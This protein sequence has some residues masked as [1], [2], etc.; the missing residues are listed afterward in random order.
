MSKNLEIAGQFARLCEI[1][2]KNGDNIRSRVYS[3][4]EEIILGFPRPI[5]D[6]NDVKG[7]PGIGSQIREKIKEYLETGKLQIIE[8][9]ENKPIMVLTNVYGIGAKKANDLIEKGIT[10]I[11]LLRERQHEV[12]NKVQKVG[13]QYYDDILKRIPRD[14]IDEYKRIF[15]KNFQ[16]TLTDNDAKFEI[17][18]SYRRG[19]ENSGDIDVIITSKN[20]D[21]FSSFID[22]LVSQNII[23]EVLSR[24]K[25]KC[26]V[27]T[28]LPDSITCRRVDFLYSTVEE[29][30]FSTLYFTGS[31]AFNVVMRGYS[32]KMGYSLNE[33]G[34]KKNG[35][36]IQD[37]FMDEKSIFDFLGLQYIPPEK[38]IDGRDII[39]FSEEKIEISQNMKKKMPKEEKHLEKER[40]K[41]EKLR[42]RILK[43]E[44]K[45]EKKKKKIII[46]E[47]QENV[48][49]KI[50]ISQNMKKKMPKEEKHLE[51]ER[52]KTEKLRD[53]EEKVEKKK[54][55]KERKKT[56][57]LRDRE[58][59]VEKKKEEKERKKTE[60]LRERILKKEEKEE[61]QKEK[62][63][64]KKSP[65]KNITRKNI[66]IISHKEKEPMVKKSIKT[67]LENFQKN[68]ISVLEEFLEKDL[69]EM[70]QY[71]NDAYYNKE[72]ILTDNEFDIL[73]EY[74]Q[75]K[76]P[77]NTTIDEIGAP[78][79]GKS[80]VTLP[81]EMASMDKIKPDSNSL[82]SWITKYKGPYV[83]SCKLDGIS[84]MYVCEKGIKKLYTRGNG[85]VGQ[86]ISHL[87]KVLG[88]PKTEG[89]AIRGE[90]IIPKQVF[91]TKYK[92]EFANARNLVAGIINKKTVDER[93]KDLHFVTYEVIHPEMP[94]GLQMETLKTL[95]FEVVQNKSIDNLSNESLSKLLVDWRE[96]YE[97]VIDGLIVS[98]DKIY[99]RVSGNPD[100][101]FAF[102]MVI[103][104][105]V[106]EAKVVDV[107][108]TP[109]K[110]GYL[111]PR[112][113]I[114][115]ISIGG[116]TI[117]YA[118]GFNGKFI[119]EN[120]IGIGAI[121]TIIRSGDV[122]PHIKSVTFP[123]S[124]P[125]MPTVPYVWTDTHV[126]IILENVGQDET[127]QEKMVTAFFVHLEVDGLS[128]GNVKRLFKEGFNTVANILRMSI[129]D[130]ESVEGFKTK[131]AEKL[132]NSIKEKVGKA[133]LLDIM[134]ASNKL[135]RGLGERKVKPILEMYPD[136]LVSIDSNETKIEKLKK[137]A[138][139]GNENA[140]SFV[141]NIG[142]FMDFLKECQ[143][144]G[145]LTGKV[146]LKPVNIVITEENKTHPLYEKKIVMTK[147]RDKEIIDSLTRLGASLVDSVKKDT[148][149]LIVK[150]KTDTSNKTEA[151]KKIGVTIMTPEEF[152]TVFL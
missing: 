123:A 149:V 113:R 112:V 107:I 91:D 97:Y 136:I 132:F 83:L 36:L 73:K 85:T 26:L 50:E 89:Y 128:K 35:T 110:N 42:E 28:K 90:F 64:K 134:V 22:S 25:S 127:V 131:M 121:I 99:P 105:Q 8:R 6:S 146:F 21:D 69:V 16:K 141:Q 71:S 58:E 9:E 12:L 126:D 82:P 108:W 86:D 84:G 119:Q 92:A 39:P 4:A 44:E 75:R 14:E 60:K 54:E 133:T 48:E 29:Y 62:Q 145:K 68:G 93:A 148:F 87:I 116:V 1:M 139:I 33:H 95:G 17:V 151:A 79:S 11:D 138:G 49:E 63:Q 152:K 37:R 81:Y 53:R 70:I 57:K 118:T 41:T 67:V 13:L 38:R 55:E 98:D 18:G 2:S 66:K 142:E 15:M 30:P 78:I 124:R 7:I 59:K 135:G 140:V 114:E 72:P 10:T 104:D 130:F 96:S 122:I 3:R 106:A 147:V 144:E 111:K 61:K 80:K 150:E 74:T 32:L 23:L 40:K 45:Q 24:G 117:E 5:T 101:S 120:N 100:H 46:L 77:D 56:E 137:V 34:F 31:K 143:L 27:I 88:L 103:S 47:K 51:K 115:P 20:P 125:K 76:Y 109:S 94:P 43:K 65:K 19:Q 129:P 52:K 102:K